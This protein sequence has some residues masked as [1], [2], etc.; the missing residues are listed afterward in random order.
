MKLPGI[1]LVTFLCPILLSA[2]DQPIDKANAARQNQEWG[3]AIRLYGK[4][5]KDHPQDSAAWY[6]L[7]MCQV[8][9][10]NYRLG[11]PNL[12]KARELNY[13]PPN[14]VS[15]NLAKAY[16]KTGYQKESIAELERLS[17]NGF[18]L[19]NRITD[20]TFEA[21]SDLPQFKEALTRI[22]SNAYPCKHNPKT[23][24]FHFWVG[25]WNCYSANGS[26]A[27]TNNIVLLEN[28]CVMQENWV[29]SGGTSTGTSYN[30]Y[31]RT[32]DK[33]QQL[34]VDNRGNALQLTGQME[35]GNMVLY[36]PETTT[37]A[38][39]TLIHRITWTPNPDGSVRQHWESSRDQQKTWT[40]AFDGT[41]RKKSEP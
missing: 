18:A 17:R 32:T 24:E 22:D 2:Q 31:N 21:Y 14:A 10:E 23:K 35:K 11:I 33:W 34:W 36:S 16:A 41:Y 9:S 28:D 6:F 29:G 15:F 8:Q 30:F 12:L 4:H 40:T 3:E 19:V 39:G 13:R 1:L 7:G 37:P 25:D 38:G 26:L 20:G 27:G 5:L